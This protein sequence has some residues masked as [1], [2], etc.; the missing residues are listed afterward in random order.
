MTGSDEITGVPDYVGEKLKVWRSKTGTVLF[1]LAVGSVPILL[2]DFA[3]NDLTSSDRTFVSIFN[4][5]VLVIFVVD[6]VTGLVLSTSK[7]GFIVHERLSGLV[8]VAS[9]LAL[10]PAVSWLGSLKLLRLVPVLRGSFGL[11]SL[12]AAGGAAALEARRIIKERA[13]KA[14]LLTT[15]LV[16]IFAASAFTLAE[17]VGSNGRYQSFFDA[18]WW[19]AATITTVGYGDIVPTTTIGRV[20]GI[21][22][23]VLG[24]SMFGI[25]TAR[26]AAAFSTDVGPSNVGH[27]E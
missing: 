17:D 12:V 5:V 1:V 23:M 21:F 26:L 20:V 3:R 2:L 24:I 11:F 15:F 9:V 18:L 6:Y 8:V 19:S 10:V 25:A 16:W 13:L 27:G 14:G 4:I 7:R 22:C